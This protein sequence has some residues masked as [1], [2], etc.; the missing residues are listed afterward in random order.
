MPMTAP[1]IDPARL[2][3]FNVVRASDPGGVDGTSR[4]SERVA[5][6][7]RIYR[8]QLQNSALWRMQFDRPIF[9]LATRG[10]GSIIASYADSRFAT[11]VSIDGDEGGLFCFT[12]LLHGHTTLIHNGDSTTATEG[13]GLALRP[14]PGTRLL[15][16]DDNVRTNVFFKVAEVE[17][18]LEH[19]LDERL[20]GP[21]EFRPNLDWS[22]G[23][24]AS[25]KCQLDLVMHEFARPDGVA[26]NPAAL[27]SMTDLLISLV[28]RGAPHNYAD[29]L[30]R[31]PAGAVPAYIR[32]AEDFM[33][34]NC[35]EPVRMAHVAAA[36]GC[37]VRTLGAVFRQFRGKTPLGALHAIRLEQAHA[38]L[39][40]GAADASVAT[41]ARRYGFTNAAR[42]TSAFRRR[43]GKTPSEAVQRASLASS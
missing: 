30:D 43:F 31:G 13:G 34:A 19:M 12:T 4:V 23:L 27:A 1:A 25:L 29:R 35:T 9:T 32:R 39:S 21:L 24:A 5:K 22:S 15:T 41:V 20:R 7:S 11:E 36:A 18:A 10:A 2:A 14:G 26:S 16:S 8:Y 38:V 42:F 40:L 3:T 33:R 6:S 17:D 28:L 37:S